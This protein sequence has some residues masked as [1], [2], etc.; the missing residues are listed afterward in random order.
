[1]MSTNWVSSFAA[2]GGKGG[3][4]GKMVETWW[5]VVAKMVNGGTSVK[6]GE[7]MVR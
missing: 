7:V 6:C 2:T 3:R 5:K 1:M 4:S